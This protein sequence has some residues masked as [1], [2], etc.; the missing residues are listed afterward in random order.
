MN[1]FDVHDILRA[2]IIV[3]LSVLAWVARGIHSQQVD[4]AKRLRAVELNQAKIMS[5]LKIEPYSS[6]DD[7]GL[8]L[9]DFSP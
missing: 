3:L 9:S 2:I 1:K 5:V 7:T 4:I 8:F 6:A